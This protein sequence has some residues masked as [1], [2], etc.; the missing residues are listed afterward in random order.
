MRQT[1]EG[2]KNIVTDPTLQTNLKAIPGDLRDTL[3]ST[4]AAADRVTN[5]LGGRRKHKTSTETGTP[6]ST[7]K[8]NKLSGAGTGFDF[9]YRRFT[10]FD[11]DKADKADLDGRNFG[12]LTFNSQ[13]FGGPFRAGLAD[14]GDNTK[15]TLQTG[16]NVGKNGALRYG[17][18]RSRLGAGIDYHLGRFSVEGNAWNPNH[19]STNG[20]LGFQVTPQ[21][22]ILAGRESIQGFRTNSIGVRLSR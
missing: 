20:Y 17:L 21:I 15:L 9:T 5:L 4:T 1:T 6:N 22:E 16:S 10:N 13:F 7:S 3:Q 19:A 8:S 11:R 12:D 14:I 2:F 18:Y